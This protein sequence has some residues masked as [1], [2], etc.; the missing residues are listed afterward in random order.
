M[1]DDTRP[2]A[3]LHGD[4]YEQYMGRWSRRVAP[5]FLRW[6]GAPPKRRW[7]DVGCGTGELSAAIQQHAEPASIVGI[8]PSDGFLSKARQR[9]GE[10][11]VLHRASAAALPLADASVDVA[12][13]ALVLNFV[14]DAGAALREMRRVTAEGGLVA[15]YVWDYRGRMDLIRHYWAAAAEIDPQRVAALD[16]GER[17]VICQPQPLT[18]LFTDAGLAQVAVTALEIEMP[19]ADF[20]AYWQPFLGGQGPAPA[21]A[22]SL[23]EADRQ[24]VQ[25]RLRARL[26][27][28]PD[29]SMVLGARAWAARGIR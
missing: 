11:V 29:G 16:Q 17:F 13:S 22:M 24:R 23:S 27:L 6:L 25:Q 19:F 14:P 2:D 9:L 7:L 20:D 21:H 1:N 5:Q 4:A 15:V 10:Q 26:P 3:W 8:D 18:A 28:Q 12:A